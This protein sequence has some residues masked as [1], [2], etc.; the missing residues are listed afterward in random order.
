MNQTENPADKNPL[1]FEQENGRA[2]A[3]ADFKNQKGERVCLA[4]LTGRLPLNPERSILQQMIDENDPT[5]K[6]SD[7]GPQPRQN[8]DGYE[9]NTKS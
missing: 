9:S 6:L 5:N 3:E 7:E 8:R 2:E 4:R 1:K